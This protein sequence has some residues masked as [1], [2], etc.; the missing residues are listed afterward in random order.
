MLSSFIPYVL[1]T[2]QTKSQNHDFAIGKGNQP[3]PLRRGGKVSIILLAAKF[4]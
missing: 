3:L 2:N 4:C 1:H